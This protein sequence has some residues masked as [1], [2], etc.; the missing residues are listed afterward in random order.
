MWPETSHYGEEKPATRRLTCRTAI[1]E[2]VE[3][4]S[5]L[6]VTGTDAWGRRLKLSGH[7][8]AV[9]K[10]LSSAGEITS[11]GHDISMTRTGG[12][13]LHASSKV[14]KDVRDALD[15]SIKKHGWEGII[16]LVV[17]RG[18]YNMYIEPD[19]VSGG[20]RPQELCAQGIVAA[21]TSGGKRPGK[22]L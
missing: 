8:A 7:K 18:V 5:R 2:F 13:I 21:S 19:S 9:H 16:E 1:G 17:E 14:L 15:K 6:M 12:F 11:R 3:S 4:G 22:R 10:P 20:A